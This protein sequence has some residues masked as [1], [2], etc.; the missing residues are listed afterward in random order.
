MSD[1]YLKAQEILSGQDGEVI[2]DWDGKT[3]DAFFVK[4]VTAS[5]SKTKEAV[6]VL[7]KRGT[8]HK[9]NGFEGTGSLGYFLVTSVFREMA[10][11]YNETGEDPYFTMTVINQ[12]PSGRLG[13]QKVI[14]YNCNL[15]EITLANLDVEASF[16]EEEVPFTF[17]DFD[18][19]EK[20]KELV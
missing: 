11:Y 14:L 6:K 18:V 20:F 3:Y 5:I 1:R 7:R 17:D 8:Q 2:I 13:K 19:P 15:D 12:D 4:K 10:V 16:L 9:V